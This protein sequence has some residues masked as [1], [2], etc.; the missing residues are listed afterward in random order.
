MDLRRERKRFMGEQEEER[1]GGLKWRNGLGWWRG[2]IER[3]KRRRGTEDE[4]EKWVG[5]VERW[6]RERQEKKKREV[7]RTEGEEVVGRD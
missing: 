6:D 4:M 3:G 2:G 5:V 1:D 7:G